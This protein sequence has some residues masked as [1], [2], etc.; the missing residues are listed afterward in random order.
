M[1]RPLLSVQGM[2]QCSVLLLLI[3]SVLVASAGVA[4]AADDTETD[5]EVSAA[6]PHVRVDLGIASPVGLVGV[7]YSRPVRPWLA[8][9]AGAGFGASGLQIS[10]MGKL[11][12]G[13]G[14]TFFTPGVGLSLGLPAG[15]G[16]PTFHTG[17]PA[18]DDEERGSPVTMAWL[19]VDLLGIEHHT[20]GGLVLS[21]SGGV[22]FALTEAHYDF[23]DMG[24]DIHRFDPVPQ[25][26]IGMGW[27][28]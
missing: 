12:L 22:T 18:G 5:A 17:H 1:V 16:E 14:R 19:D 9:E 27:T 3:A 15:G 2:R 8:L 20:R 11:R 23:A 24:S 28:F 21:A 26:R 10:G 6:R 4:R 13:N 7:V 25:V